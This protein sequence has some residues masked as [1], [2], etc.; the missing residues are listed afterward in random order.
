MPNCRWAKL[1]YNWQNFFKI[2][3]WHYKWLHLTAKGAKARDQFKI[4]M[5]SLFNKSDLDL[6]SQFHR[7]GCKNESPTF[8]W[9][10]ILYKRLGKWDFRS[11]ERKRMMNSTINPPEHSQAP[12]H[13]VPNGKLDLLNRDIVKL[14]IITHVII[15]KSTFP[16]KVTVNKHQISPS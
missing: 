4:Q 2:S 6:A 3:D 7:D 12:I 14:R 13:R 5:H 9:R 16:Q 8:F 1:D 11:R 15:W 10:W